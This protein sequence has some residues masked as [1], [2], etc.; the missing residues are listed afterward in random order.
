M[1]GGGARLGAA[2]LSLWLASAAAGSAVPDPPVLVQR[3]TKICQVLGECD[4]E[5]GGAGTCTNGLR[6]QPTLNLTESRYGLFGTD[7]GASF[8]HNGQLFFLFGD[9]IPSGFHAPPTA[10]PHDSDSI[11]SSTDTDP[12]DCLSLQFV[13]AAD[14]YYLPL[15]VEIPP[16]DPAAPVDLGSFETPVGG[17]SANGNMYVFFTT[18]AVTSPTITLGRSVLGKSTDGG[19]SFTHVYDASTDKFINV[20]PVVVNNADVPALPVSTGQGLLLWASSTAY[21]KSDPYLAY[22]PLDSVED[23]TTWRYFAGTKSGQPVWSAAEASAVPLFATAPCIG[24]LSVSWNP[25]LRNWLMLYNCLDPRGINLRAA[26]LP[27]GPWSSTA[28]IFDPVAD[29]GYCHFIHWSDAVSPTPLGA[30]APCDNLSDPGANNTFGGEYGPYFI[31]RYT[32]ADTTSTTIYH[33]MSTFNPYTAV[34]MKATLRTSCAPAPL[35]GCGKPAA[36]ASTVQLKRNAKI[37]KSAVNWTWNKGAATALADFGDPT[38][39]TAYGLCVYDSTPAL[40]LSLSAPAGGSCAGKACWASTKAGFKY[41]NKDATPDGLSQLQL[42]AGAAGKA[43]IVAK[44]KGPNLAMPAF[45]LLQDP[46]VVVQVQ[47][48]DGGCWEADYSAPAKKNDSAQ[49]N[50]TSD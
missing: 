27:W 47:N 13:T 16:G 48:S 44:G 21:R 37:S 10:R 14:G 38:T 41:T 18:D 9:T 26:S 43:K 11:A 2:A 28:V 36:A 40:V 39:R 45:P 35:A 22:V 25:F 23:H 1:K 32:R 31:S 4:R 46:T 20:A 12:D 30:S 3:S 8:E 19:R 17:F 7:L 42:T 33:L 34:L 6:G 49:L 50:D 15:Q 5:R 29:S 24:E